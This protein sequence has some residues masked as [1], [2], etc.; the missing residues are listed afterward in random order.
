MEGYLVLEDGTIFRGEAIG[1]SSS[2]HGEVVFATGMTG[3]QEVLTDP[4][5]CGQIVVLTYPLIGNYGLN[6]EDEEADRPNALGLVVH[7]ACP[8]PSH[9]RAAEDLASYLQRHRL[10]AIQGVDTRALTRH[11][12]NRGTMRGILACGGADLEELKLLAPQVPPLHGDQLVPA[13][14]NTETYVLTGGSPRIA[15]YNL[16]VKR[17]ILRWFQRRGC[18]VIVM[19]ARSTAADILAMRPHGVVISNGPGNPKDVPYGVQTVRDLLGRVPLLG[20]CLGHQLIALALGGDTYKL[21]FGHRGVNH[22]VKELTSGR[23]YITAQNHGYAIRAD[24][25]PPEVYI[26]HINLNDG[27]VEGLG[28]RYLP[29]FSVQY[30]PEAAP[31]PSD[32]A[33]ILQRFLDLVTGGREVV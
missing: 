26:S 15:V 2:C 13:V 33:H 1:Y 12:R 8:E 24:S 4:S 30:H 11:L 29:V 23:V 16:G 5:Y 25:L 19:P 17:S 22:P 7:E 31:G 20:I 9:W 28:H 10:P 6:P 21:S 14:T 32:S 18:T 3:Y 27:T